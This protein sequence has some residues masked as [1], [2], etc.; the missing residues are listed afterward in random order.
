[1]GELPLSRK[2]KQSPGGR[3]RKKSKEALDKK[4][5]KAQDPLRGGGIV[6]YSKASNPSR[7]LRDLDGERNIPAKKGGGPRAQQERR[8]DGLPSSNV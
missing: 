7:G 8:L 1:V 2:D 5:K 4:R 3:Q 6:W